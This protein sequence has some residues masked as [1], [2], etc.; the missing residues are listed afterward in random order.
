[1]LSFD[2]LLNRSK[3]WADMVDEDSLG[4]DFETPLD[5]GAG[6]SKSAPAAFDPELDCS[7]D[8]LN[9]AFRT[10]LTT[11]PAEGQAAGPLASKA[12][13]FSS[14]QPTATPS[15]STS[16]A[17]TPATVVAAG[18]LT[19]SDPLSTPE[20]RKP[21]SKA[22]NKK[23]PSKS[24]SAAHNL[25]AAASKVQDDEMAT[26]PEEEGGVGAGSES[27]EVG[28][29]RDQ[30]SPSSS[31]SLD[32]KD[33]SKPKQ[34]KEPKRA[35]TGAGPGEEETACE[36]DD[37]EDDDGEEGGIET[38]PIRLAWRTKQ[39]AY[40]KC[41][42]GYRLY[43]KQVPKSKRR[44]Y[45]PST[46]DIHRKCSKRA[47]AGLV[48]AWRRYLHKYDPTPA[49]ESPGFQRGD[50]EQ[51]FPPLS[52]S[53]SSNTNTPA[54]TGAGGAAAGSGTPV[55]SSSGGSSSS[56]ANMQ[57]VWAAAAAAVAAGAGDS[58]FHITDGL[59]MK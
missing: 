59:M 31:V 6:R 25:S 52:R 9:L 17:S 44:H 16:G 45:H 53:S 30:S 20:A 12:G 40:G 26:V 4:A 43:V 14:S 34:A 27:P 37:D 18:S 42:E 24:V 35:R 7:R 5:L 49:P 22:N 10:G 2:A 58:P 15:K 32:D 39:I 47:F 56:V 23:N 48:R 51:A 36:D 29:K 11:V 41:S 57:S 55:R 13:L 1:M 8:G 54:A 3:S 50:D 19:P 21:H 33:S 46:P 38:D 28:K